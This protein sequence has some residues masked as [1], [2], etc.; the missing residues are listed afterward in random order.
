MNKA[1]FIVLVCFISCFYN[2]A[3]TQNL[4][5]DGNFEARNPN[6]NNFYINE[7]LYQVL[8]HW[9]D[10]WGK[11]RYI[12]SLN[13]LGSYIPEK[14]TSGIIDTLDAPFSG[15]GCIFFD[16]EHLTKDT[17]SL[18]LIPFYKDK[19]KFGVGD[20]FYRFAAEW[21]NAG[22]F[23]ELSTPLQ[24]DSFYYLSFRLKFGSKLN[25]RIT[26]TPFYTNIFSYF[27]AHF[28]TER[29]YHPRNDVDPLN[30]IEKIGVSNYKKEL[31]D[32]VLDTTYQWRKVEMYFKAD[33]AY[34][35]IYFSQFQWINTMKYLIKTMFKSYLNLSKVTIGEAN[36]VIMIDDVKLLPESL[37]IQTS[38]DTHICENT[39]AHLKVLKGRG[40]Y[41]WHDRRY[42]Y[43]TLS[44]TDA[45]TVWP[46][47]SVT[48]YE[49]TSPYDTSS[50]VV[51]AHKPQTVYD[52]IIW[53]NCQNQSYEID[54]PKGALWNDGTVHTIAKK[55]NTSGIYTYSF[56]DK[57]TTYYKT[58][59][60]TIRKPYI[61][62][63][64][65]T[66]CDQYTWRGKTYRQSGTYTDSLKGRFG[67]DSIY[68]LN[69]NIKKSIYDTIRINT[70]NMYRYGDSVYNKSGTYSFRYTAS[71]GCDSIVVLQMT[72][73][74]VSAEIEV[75][76][77]IHFR[78]LKPNLVYQWYLCDAWR[79]IENAFQQTLT[80]TTKARFTVVVSDSLNRCRDT[81]LC[82]DKWYSSIN[83]SSSFNEIE[84]YP[85]PITEILHISSPQTMPCLIFNPLGQKVVEATISKNTNNTLS[86]AHLTSG[87]YFVHFPEI[88]KVFKVR[89]E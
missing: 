35:F 25:S 14:I 26:K 75:I 62:T 13:P 36:G 24:K 11:S 19:N 12:N 27:G 56:F 10:A 72:S 49:V 44:Y 51:Y 80:T 17:N 71:N 2:V 58:Y 85:N 65:I 60:I 88:N 21:S 5:R 39:S 4:I 41:T 82:V 81:S 46:Q 23:Q 52:T 68:I 63:E 47:D 83:N 37:Y 48:V 8:L 20:S 43:T 6:I 64:N 28:T 77:Q 29:I 67:C 78:A 7:G 57:C 31:Q 9:K 73:L 15:K 38:Q 70:C 33:S 86:L 87:I 61:F 89:K 1:Y 53:S 66:N 18:E 76:D 74:E 84:L 34:R 59:Q 69:L 55:I 50:V 54:A 40:P 30:P 45:V 42:P 16:L 32:T 79:K 3:H 22:F